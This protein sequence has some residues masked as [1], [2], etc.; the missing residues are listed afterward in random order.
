MFSF[1]YSDESELANAVS[2]SGD[3]KEALQGPLVYVIILLGSILAFWQNSLI[4]IVALSVMAA[5]D[6]VSYNYFLHLFQ[7]YL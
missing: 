4:G 2:R 5:G 1:L 3:N 6:G 7:Y